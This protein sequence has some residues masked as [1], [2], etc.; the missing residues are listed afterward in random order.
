[1]NRV[2]RI[3][4]RARRRRRVRRTAR[5]FGHGMVA[6]AAVAVAVVG[7]DRWFGLGLSWWWLAGGPGLVVALLT[8]PA[9]MQR[10][11][12]EAAAHELDER[13][14][15]SDRLGTGVWF[16][17]H[18]PE[19]GGDG[20]GGGPFERLALRTRSGRRARRTWRRGRRSR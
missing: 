1:M 7:V 6:G 5:A 11:T 10:D 18:A 19:P 16:G 8:A 14:G 13:L 17:A 3:A 15:L 20:G 2:T 4:R 9:A 12:L